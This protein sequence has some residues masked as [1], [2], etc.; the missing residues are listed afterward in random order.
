MPVRRPT[1]TSDSDDAAAGANCV[2]S[3]PKIAVVNVW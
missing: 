3:S 1:S 2:R